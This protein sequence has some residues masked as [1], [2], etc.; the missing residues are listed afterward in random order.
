MKKSII[1]VILLLSLLLGLCGCDSKNND[2][3]ITLSDY[4][5]E[6]S[7]TFERRDICLEGYEFTSMNKMFY[8]GENTVYI[9]SGQDEGFVLF[10]LDLETET[11]TE[12]GY[13]TSC[14]IWDFDITPS[15]TL[16]ILES[17]NDADKVLLKEVSQG[18]ELI[19]E[20][21]IDTVAMEA[22]GPSSNGDTFLNH[23]ACLND[24]MLF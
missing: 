10:R 19:R 1:S 24:K 7:P 21:D 4:S 16:M 13:E 20:L 3:T 8:E 5:G 6:A 12:L 22:V 11:V 17:D 23:L 9:A 15:G 2:G 18:G 14:F